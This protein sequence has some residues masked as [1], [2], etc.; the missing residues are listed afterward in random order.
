MS[1]SITEL[2]AENKPTL[3][4]V[5]GSCPSFFDFCFCYI[6]LLTL[7]RCTDNPCSCI[8]RLSLCFWRCL[9]A[10]VSPKFESCYVM[11]CH[12]SRLHFLVQTAIL[13][14]P[15]PNQVRKPK[16]NRNTM[17]QCTL[18]LSSVLYPRPTISIASMISLAG[19]HHFLAQ[20]QHPRY[21]RLL[22]SR[23][24]PHF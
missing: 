4:D 7:T 13:I 19:Q 23:L 8:H 22:S 15:G 1:R 10:A 3:L 14:M 9:R 17:L 11:L 12:L 24:H 18:Q 2:A 20:P 6:T 5:N 16:S 21:L